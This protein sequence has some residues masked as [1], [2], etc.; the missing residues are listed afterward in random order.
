[1]QCWVQF[2]V[3]EVVKLMWI[4]GI[5]RVWSCARCVSHRGVVESLVMDGAA[6]S[7]GSF[8]SRCVRWTGDSRLSCFLYL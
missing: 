7:D 2:R 3:F 1:M 5:P 4:E 6:L 8:A